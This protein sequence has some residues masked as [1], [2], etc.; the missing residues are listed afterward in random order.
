MGALALTAS[1]ALDRPLVDPEGF[2]GPAVVRL[3]L[4]VLGAFL[5]DLLP[6][7]LWG[8][9]MKPALMPA[10]ARERVRTHWDRERITLDG[11]R[12]GVLLH[13]LRLLPE[14]Q[15]VPPLHHGRGQVRPGAAPRRPGA[16]VRPRARDD[17]AHH[18]R[19]G[20]LGALP[21]DDLPVVPAAGAARA[22][23]LAGVVA[24]HH[25]RLLVR[26]LPVPGVDARHRVLLRPA[27]PRARLPVQLP[28]RRP[29]PHRLDRADGGAVVRPRRRAAPRASRARCSRWPASRPCTSRS[30]CWWR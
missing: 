26:H 10:I 2:L 6:R 11:A 16:D 25:L 18:P 19:H 12:A 5:L 15:V 7:T 29:R 1:F 22:R 17:P 21:V 28:L 13:H 4:I 24:Q 23:G 8:S 9:R 14:P 20:D 3:P 30:P 27:D